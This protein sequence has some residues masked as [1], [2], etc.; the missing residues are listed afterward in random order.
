MKKV[1][2]VLMTALLVFVVGMASYTAGQ[3]NM[4]EVSIAEVY[5]EDSILE[6]VNEVR[7]EH[8]LSRFTPD[9]ELSQ[10]AQRRAD[11]MAAAHTFSH[12]GWIQTYYK[13]AKNPGRQHITENI[14][15]CYTSNKELVE[16]WKASPKHYEAMV[17]PLYNKVGVGTTWDFQKNCLIAVN[18]FAD[19]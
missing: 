10:V 5:Q 17:S 18:F 15:E 2:Y 12:D 4:R 14:G 13:I 6:Y 8:G 1:I 3:T 9:T 16:A 19:Q 11:D 7:A